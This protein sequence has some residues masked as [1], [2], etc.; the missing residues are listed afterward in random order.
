MSVDA[1]NAASRKSH[2]PRGF[3]RRIPLPGERELHLNGSMGLRPRSYRFKIRSNKGL[4]PSLSLHGRRSEI[5]VS[6][7]DGPRIRREN[8]QRASRIERAINETLGSKTPVRF[9]RDEQGNYYG[10]GSYPVQA[11]GVIGPDEDPF[12]FR[13]R[14][15]HAHLTVHDSVE[16]DAYDNPVARMT[17]GMD[18]VYPDDDGYEGDFRSESDMVET[19]CR[20]ARELSPVDIATNPTRVQQMG[21]S[22]LMIGLANLVDGGKRDLRKEAT[23]FAERGDDETAQHFQQEWE[24]LPEVAAWVAAGRPD[25]GAIIDLLEGDEGE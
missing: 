3:Y 21:A 13:L 4:N 10:W 19:F 8:Q 1:F 23:F 15:N 20:L 7:S 14:Y 18:D 25:E 2:R 24:A 6:I 22:L 5:G 16:R 12:Y 11:E 9:Q 17:A